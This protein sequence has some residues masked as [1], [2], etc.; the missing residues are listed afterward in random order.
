MVD[1][2][3]EYHNTHFDCSLTDND[4]WEMDHKDVPRELY[5]VCVDGICDPLINEFG[6]LE[7]YFYYEEEKEFR[8]EIYINE[9]IYE[10]FKA[11]W[12]ER[13]GEKCTPKSMLKR[14][15]ETIDE[16]Y[17]YIHFKFKKVEPFYD[18]IQLAFTGHCQEQIYIYSKNGNWFV[19][20]SIK[21]KAFFT[22]E[23]EL[24]KYIKKHYPKHYNNYIWV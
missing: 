21:E 4:Y 1:E 5:D 9:D 16:E 15:S 11:D 17:P 6:N 18:Y 7:F 10:D 14:M 13:Y 20:D 2:L 24:K 3:L 23:K 8:V 12:K 22:D 19:L